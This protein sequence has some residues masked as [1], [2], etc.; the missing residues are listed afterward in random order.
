MSQAP[1]EITANILSFI[2]DC[3][4]VYGLTN[5]CDMSPMDR[6]MRG[7]FDNSMKTM[8][9]VINQCPAIFDNLSFTADEIISILP[10]VTSQ[11]TYNYIA[12]RV[13]WDSMLLTSIYDNVISHPLIADSFEG[14]AIKYFYCRASGHRCDIDVLDICDMALE[15]PNIMLTVVHTGDLEVMMKLADKFFDDMF[16]LANRSDHYEWLTMCAT[17]MDDYAKAYTRAD[18]PHMPRFAMT[19]EDEL[20]YE[21]LE[22]M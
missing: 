4:N 19:T 16:A 5:I 10:H 12:H 22:R 1:P 20:F 3:T 18:N 6:A 13:L 9:D 14:H 15:Y 21:S 2:G 7:V 17:D 11:T 8:I